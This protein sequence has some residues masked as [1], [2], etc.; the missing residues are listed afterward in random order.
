MNAVKK[1]ID[2]FEELGEGEQEKL[3]RELDNRG[4]K[5]FEAHRFNLYLTGYNCSPKTAASLIFLLK[6]N[7]TFKDDKLVLRYHDIDDIREFINKKDYSKPFAIL[8]SNSKATVQ[9][10]KDCFEN[11]IKF[12]IV[13]RVS[14][15]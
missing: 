15:L 2:M 4:Y 7:Q 12:K 13:A 6:S 14:S 8:D 10:L 5:L 9:R 11:N 3:A 1:I